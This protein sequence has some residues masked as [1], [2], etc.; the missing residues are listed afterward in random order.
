MGKIRDLSNQKFG[1]LKVT[2]FAGKYKNR[3]SLWRCKCEC[4]NETIVLGNDLSR[5]HTK[6]CGKCS[7][8]IFYQE[9]DYMVGV[10]TKGE[11]FIFDIEDF[12][13]ISKHTWSN[14]GRGYLA[15]CINGKNI[16]LHRFIMK[17]SDKEIVDHIFGDT[18]DNRRGKLRICDHQQNGCNRRKH[19]TTNTNFK[20]IGW[21]EESN[22]WYARITVNKKK[23]WLGYFDNETDAAN[24]YN[25][26][27]KI[28]FGEFALLNVIQ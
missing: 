1:K 6:S 17:P 27:A 14:K 28:Y 16:R 25:E 13:E 12:G 8:N 9:N 19:K 22:K 2:D 3:Y 23:V 10:T 24:A 15:A 7:A 4:G 26:A 5:G 21:V 20:G 11:K 18:F